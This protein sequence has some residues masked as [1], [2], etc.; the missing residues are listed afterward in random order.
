MYLNYTKDVMDIM[1]QLRQEWGFTYP[2]EE[3]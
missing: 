3:K 2:E 1:T